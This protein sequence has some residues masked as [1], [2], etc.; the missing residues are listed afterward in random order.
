MYG[1]DKRGFR[2]PEDRVLDILPHAD[3]ATGSV[4]LDADHLFG[5]IYVRG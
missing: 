2:G 3:E 1:D 5:L 4:E